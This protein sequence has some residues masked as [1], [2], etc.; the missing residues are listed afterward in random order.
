[1]PKNKKQ[2]SIEFCDSIWP[3][4]KFVSRSLQLDQK[5][6]DI[7]DKLGRINVLGELPLQ[8]TKYFDMSSSMRKLLIKIQTKTYTKC[9]SDGCVYFKKVHNLNDRASGMLWEKLD[10]KD[11]A[12]YNKIASMTGSNRTDCLSRYKRQHLNW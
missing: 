2:S 5:I 11:K 9:R 6:W 10:S 7:D 1:M 8:T 3:I 4:S 12:L